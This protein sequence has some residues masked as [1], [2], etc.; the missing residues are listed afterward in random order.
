VGHAPGRELARIGDDATRE[1]LSGARAL[2]LAHGSEQTVV[3]ANACAAHTIVRT[4]LRDAAL[5]LPLVP[6]ANRTARKLRLRARVHTAAVAILAEEV[7]A[8]AEVSTVVRVARFDARGSPAGRAAFAIPSVTAGA[9]VARV[10]DEVGGN[11]TRTSRDECSERH[12]RGAKR[13]V[14]APGQS[15]PQRRSSVA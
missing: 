2:L 6:F 1:T 11:G 10:G 13:S 12:Q 7:A 4:I 15:G 14:A 5:G 3:A 9:A 8:T